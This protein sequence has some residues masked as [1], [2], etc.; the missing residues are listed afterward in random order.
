MIWVIV[1]EKVYTL[2]YIMFL[3]PLYDDL[4]IPRLRWRGTA[5]L[6]KSF[7]YVLRCRRCPH[8]AV[9]KVC[10]ALEDFGLYGK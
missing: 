10:M 1:G 8:R 7:N 6:L 4:N 9:G 3:A 5:K 2:Q